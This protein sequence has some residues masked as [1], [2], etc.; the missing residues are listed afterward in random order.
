MSQTPSRHQHRLD[1]GASPARGLR[2]AGLLA[3]GLGIAVATAP[4]AGAD[5]ESSLRRRIRSFRERLKGLRKEQR[6]ERRLVLSELRGALRN[7]VDPVKPSWRE[8]KHGKGSLSLGPGGLPILRLRGTP[9]EIGAQHGT[10]LKREIK[11]LV[12]RYLPGFLGS[13]L[14]KARRD[15]RRFLP[16]ISEARIR[17]MR[18]MAK[19]AGVSFEDVLLAQTFADQ[20]RA[21][22][23]SCV[24]ATGDARPSGPA[25][26][27]NLDFIDMGFLH[28]FSLIVVIEPADGRR[29][30]SVS[31]PGL[32]G[33]ISGMNEDGLAAAVMVVHTGSGCAT[34]TPFGLLFRD[35]LERCKT[36]SQVPA[37]LSGSTPTPTM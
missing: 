15:A 3:L 32:C 23:C 35:V 16:H 22:G 1:R 31:F 21:W 30:A 27:R 34:G 20:Y 13:E 12:D 36:S 26:G 25:F 11:V 19:A 4:T 18:A 33:V 6:M 37:V 8:A 29:V 5:G 9:E 17:E 14:A 2:N 10:L 7:L 24:T 28:R